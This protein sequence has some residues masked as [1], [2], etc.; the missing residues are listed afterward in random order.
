MSGH[1]SARSYAGPMG[2]FSLRGRSHRGSRGAFDRRHNRARRRVRVARHQ[3]RRT[4]GACS[5]ET[6]EAPGDQRKPSF[7]SWEST[8]LK[9][10]AS[11]DPH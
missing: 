7:T 6:S 8:F 1:T 9:I 3:Y 10:I 4:I 11:H 2:L 5:V